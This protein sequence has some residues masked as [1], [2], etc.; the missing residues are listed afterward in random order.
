MRK[1]LL[2]LAAVLN[3]FI[4]LSGQ[5]W[6]VPDN[7]RG[8]LSPFP[9][10][11]DTRKAGETSYNTNCLSCHGNPGKG[12]VINLVPPPPD[13]ST[14]KFQKNTDGEI[15]Y[16]IAEGRLQMPAFRNV[17]NSTEIWN[18][19]SFIRSFNRAY[20]QVV[21]P[22]ITS[23]AYPGAEIILRLGFM[24]DDTSVVVRALA[25]TEQSSVPVTDAGL[26]LF[27]KRTFGFMPV[28][29]EQFTDNN[30]LAKFRLP[31]GLPGDTAGNLNFS[32]R[33]SDEDS[34]GEFSRDTIMKAG[35]LTIPVSLVAQRAMWNKSRMAPVWVIAV[36]LCGVLAVWGFI[37]FILLKLRDVYIIGKTLSPR[38]LNDE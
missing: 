34:F 21:M 33:F 9:F 31:D 36:Y 32:A 19:V 35:E 1:T 2:I 3:T 17:L 28:D 37:F 16:K 24:P 7:R 12:N 38:N 25:V 8:R 29:E 20:K 15:F 11:E 4:T 26:R 22:V 13:P 30:G 5:E 18:I 6:I 14:E 10:N 27:V 23:S